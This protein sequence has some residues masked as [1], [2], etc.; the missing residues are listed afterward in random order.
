[1]T[2]YLYWFTGLTGTGKRNSK[3][4]LYGEN[5]DLEYD[6]SYKLK[7][8]PIDTI[9]DWEVIYC[10]NSGIDELIEVG[11]QDKTLKREEGS[12]KK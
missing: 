5:G 4:I 8:K 1:M 11:V 3:I 2:S 10:K 7:Y 6:G 9:E 12:N